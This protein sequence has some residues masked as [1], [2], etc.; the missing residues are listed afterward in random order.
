MEINERRKLI[1][2][3]AWDKIFE[4]L[5]TDFPSVRFED[6]GS[7][8]LAIFKGKSF[9]SIAPHDPSD[10]PLH[11]RAS[12]QGELV[13][14]SSADYVVSICENSEPINSP[15]TA[16][17][18]ISF[19]SATLTLPEDMADPPFKDTA[20]VTVSQALAAGWEPLSDRLL[21]KQVTYLPISPEEIQKKLQKSRHARSID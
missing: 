3:T 14:G 1:S 13:T 10:Q 4:N 12:W 21:R 16:W 7:S 20:F 17:A 8:I 18:L 6:H 5:K 11:W 9:C 15:K 19:P 2:D